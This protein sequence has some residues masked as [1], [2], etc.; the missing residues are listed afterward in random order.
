VTWCYESW[1][2]PGDGPDT[3]IKRA[4]IRKRSFFATSSCSRS[5]LNSEV[6]ECPLCQIATWSNGSVPPVRHLDKLAVEELFAAAII[7]AFWKTAFE[8]SALPA[9]P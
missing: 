5:W 6:R 7:A 1:S 3:L 9:R 4:R 8:I 2:R